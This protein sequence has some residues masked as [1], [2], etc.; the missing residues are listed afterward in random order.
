MKRTLKVGLT[1]V[2]IIVAVSCGYFY[3]KR[4]GPSHGGAQEQAHKT[5]YT[6]PMHPFIIKSQP[7]ACDI[8]GM[9]LVK[10]IEGGGISGNELRNVSHVALSPSNRVIANVAVTAAAVKPFSREITCTGIVAYNQERQGKVSAW[11]AGRLDRLLVKS[12]GSAV[13]KDVPVAE[14]YSVDLYN[15]EVQ[16]LLAYKTIKILNSSLS[17]TFPINT[18]MSLGDAHERL[19]QLGF[20]EKQFDQLQKS[21]KPSIRIPIYSPLSGVVTEKFVQE[22]QYVNIGEPLFAIADLSRVWV[23][24]ELFESDFALV[25]TGQE[26]AI[27]A[28]SYPGQLFRGRVSLIY[29]FLNPK[30][31]T[32]RVRVTLPNPGLKLKPEMFVTGVIKVH[33]ADSLVVPAGAVMVTGKRQVVWVET[34]PGV[35]VP[36]D[37]TTGA[38]SAGEVQILAGLKAGEKVAV[39]G[40]YLIDSEAQLSRGGEV[41]AQPPAAPAKPATAPV[42][43]DEMDMKDMKMH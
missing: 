18:Q 11:V 34:Q 5:E 36:R 31:R 42:H 9:D 29:P 28:K 41:A 10:K 38:R 33:L 23:E 1:A 14:L 7:G 13:R 30:T 15:A 27:S 26:V 24:L 22:G 8:C 43:K 32:V 12:V 16:Y 3:G 20:K 19:R 40:A 6:C 17:V 21:I 39:S 25:R 4:T 37:V 2:V 35:F